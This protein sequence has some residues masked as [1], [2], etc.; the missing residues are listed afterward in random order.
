MKARCCFAF[1]ALFFVSAIAMAQDKKDDKKPEEKKK[2]EHPA[3]DE[4]RAV[5]SA[6]EDAFNKK[7]VD[8]LLKHV[9]KNVVVTWQNGEVS[10]GHQGETKSGHKGIKEY[11][12]RMLTGEASVLAKVEAKP[13]LEE[14]SIL[15]GDPPTTAIAY[16]KLKDEYKLRDGTLIKMDSRFSAALVKE[17]GKW[18]IVNFHGST[19]VF[20][21]AVMDM[22]IKKTMW[23]TAGAVGLAALLIG[24]IIGRLMGGK[25]TA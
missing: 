20:G 12:D 13:E 7:D 14:L 6:L 9:H 25:K 11:Y 19:N 17:D 3:H 15:Y 22:A 2:D 1:A 18:L 16:G 10:R 8:A 23:M 4:L 24:L 5:K 21:N